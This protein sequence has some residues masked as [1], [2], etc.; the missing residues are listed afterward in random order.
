MRHYIIIIL[1]TLIFIGVSC[2]ANH[3]GNDEVCNDTFAIWMLELKADSCV[4][5]YQYS[6][7]V[8]SLQTIVSQYG[9]A[10]DSADLCD[11]QNSIRL[12]ASIASVKPQCIHKQCDMII[13][14]YQNEFSHL[15]VPVL[16]N[17][18]TVGF[19]FDTGANLSTITQSVA[20]EMDL[21]MINADV[22]VG[23]S[24]D[25]DVTSQLAVADS[26]EIGG[27]LYE[28]VVF[29]VLPDEMLS[30]PSIGYE[31]HGII[32]FP[33][34]SQME[35]IRMNQDGTIFTPL[36]PID[37]GFQN[38]YFDG[39]SII[40]QLIHENDTLHF[41]LDTGA[42]SSQLS[43]KYIE[44]HKEEIVA[45][46]KLQH[47]HRGGAGGMVEVDEYVIDDFTYIIGSQSNTLKHMP[48]SM[49]ESHSQYEGVIGQDIF[50]QF[51]TMILNFRYMYIDFE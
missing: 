44:T 51:D 24:T 42:N 45:H 26:I 15:I 20:E 16:C 14:T 43:R 32:G 31:I 3:K 13:P 38:M 46:A 17:G 7:A 8:E 49:D 9:H 21:K 50:A 11:Y 35:E 4:R 23:S 18:K 48:V 29:L 41:F 33:V 27:I 6:E 28:N 39:Q 36:E 25:I 40:V 5:N 19:V 37:K 1:C 47:V 34:I 22:T 30:F 2:K 10:I 12:Y